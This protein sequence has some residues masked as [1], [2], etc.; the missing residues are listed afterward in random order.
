MQ[1]FS[2]EMEPRV[3]AYEK[4]MPAAQMGYQREAF[5]K[6]REMSQNLPSRKLLKSFRLTYFAPFA[7]R[8]KKQSPGRSNELLSR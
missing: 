7:C 2:D 5:Q 4:I 3:L 1:S 8:L 6:L